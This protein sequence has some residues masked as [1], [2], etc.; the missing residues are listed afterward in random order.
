MLPGHNVVAN[1]LSK[2]F[3]LNRPLT[4][5]LA[6]RFMDAEFTFVIRYIRQGPKHSYDLSVDEAN[7]ILESGLGLMIV[8]HVPLPGWVP[9]ATAGDTRGKVAAAECRLLGYPPGSMVWL[10]LEGVALD[11]TKP[12]VINYC[13]NWHKA[14]ASAGYL[15]GIYVGFQPGI[16]ARSLYYDLRF[17]HYWAAYNVDVKPAIRGYQMFQHPTDKMVSGIDYDVDLV[18]A[19]ALG[20]LPSYLVLNNP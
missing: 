9:T 18:E 2:G 10:D 5:S 11:A 19:D 14:V 13:N 6:Q 3:D 17:T 20:S 7:L 12:S 8:Q 15:P 16:D 4:R 1:R